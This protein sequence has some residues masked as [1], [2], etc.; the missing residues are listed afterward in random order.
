M[1]ETLDE[2]APTR[3]MG[4]E[5]CWQRIADAPYGRLAAA[6]GGE[7]D[8]FPVNHAVDDRTIVFRTSPGTKLL[9]LTIRH[10]IAFEVDGTDETE[11]FSVVVKGQAEEF[12]RQAEIFEAERLGVSPWAPEEKDRWV[13]ITPDEVHGRAFQLPPGRLGS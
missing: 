10:R 6:A 8:I 12:D 9:E 13:R 4:E 11:A 7:V 3:R 1:D 2:R 5:E